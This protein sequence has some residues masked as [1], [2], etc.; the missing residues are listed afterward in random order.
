MV[1]RLHEAA[2]ARSRVRLR[3]LQDHAEVL[4]VDLLEAPVD[5]PTQSLVGA[6]EGVLDLRLRPFQILTLRIRRR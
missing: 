5:E 2:G 3:V 1:V 6:A 4:E